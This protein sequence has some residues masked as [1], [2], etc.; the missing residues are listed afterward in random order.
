M[1]RPDL[2]RVPGFYHKYINLVKE[3]D[4]TTAFTN[5]SISMFSFFGSIPEAKHDFAYAEGKWTVKELLQ[6]MLDAERV[7]V[8]RA[9]TFSRKDENK[10][11]GFD[12][13]AWT[14]QSNAAARNWKD[15]I[16][17]FTSLRKSTELMFGSFS[18][19]QLN[20]TGIANNN[21][22]YVLA[23]GFITIGHC[24]HHIG[25]LKERYF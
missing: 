20:S 6:H 10:L 8:Y 4:L 19:E 9:L 5:Q 3:D 24:D 18:A 22:V 17:E 21:P 14:P 7:F 15:I 1:P 25:I 23:L 2:S 13:N 11:P 16:E 12:E